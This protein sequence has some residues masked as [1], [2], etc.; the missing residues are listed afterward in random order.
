MMH[1]KVLQK[2]EGMQTESLHGTNVL[3]GT[4]VWTS[5]NNTVTSTPGLMKKQV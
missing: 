1:E 3:A 2:S 5:L 4:S